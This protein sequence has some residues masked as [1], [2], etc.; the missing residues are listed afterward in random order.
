MCSQPS[1]VQLDWR[2]PKLTRTDRS[3]TGAPSQM[4]VGSHRA[5]VTGVKESGDTVV[6][7]MLPVTSS[8]LTSL[9]LGQRWSG[10]AYPWRVTQ[11]PIANSSS[12][13]LSD[14]TL[15]QWALGSSW[16]RTHVSRVW[17]Q[18]M[19]VEGID[20]IEWPQCFT[21]LNPIEHLRD[22]MYRCIQ[23]P[24]SSLMPWSRSGRRSPGH[25]QQEHVRGHT[26]YWDTLWVTVMTFMQVGFNSTC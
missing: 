21:D 19:D 16:C 4:R 23:V 9:V 17:Q 2:S 6:N 11:T 22:V 10:G 12:Q 20:A 5:H 25:L 1:T 13:R 24:P 18:F 3:T 14:L 15:V 26:H 7:V 8:S